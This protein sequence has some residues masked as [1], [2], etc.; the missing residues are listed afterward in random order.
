MTVSD[1][2]SSNFGFL[3]NCCRGFEEEES[4]ARVKAR[5]EGA[6]REIRISGNGP[7]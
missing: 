1:I 4:I 6:P 3:K 2:T 5:Q 7:P